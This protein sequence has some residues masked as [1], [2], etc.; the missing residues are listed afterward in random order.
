MEKHN[1]KADAVG[2]SWTYCIYKAVQTVQMRIRA[3][4]AELPDLPSLNLSMEQAQHCGVFAR[5]ECYER[6]QEHVLGHCTFLDRL[7]GA[8]RKAASKAQIIK[9]CKVTVW[10]Q[11]GSERR[12]LGFASALGSNS[13]RSTGTTTI[14]TSIST[15]AA[16]FSILTSTS[17]P[18][19]SFDLQS[20]ALCSSGMAS[21]RRWVLMRP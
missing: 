17:N 19:L 11:T 15:S 2:G 3:I 13:R 6:R 16:A 5:A 1:A 18:I 9:S 4:V 14:T 8:S 12:R 7:G 20:H 10:Q 21:G